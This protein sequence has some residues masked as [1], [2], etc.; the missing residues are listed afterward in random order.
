[1]LRRGGKP[2]LYPTRSPQASYMPGRQWAPPKHGSQF[3]SRGS[4]ASKGTAGRHHL[5][6]RQE[7]CS[8]HHCTQTWMPHSLATCT[9]GR[10]LQTGA[11]ACIQ[12][13]FSPIN[14][15][16]KPWL[17]LQIIQCIFASFTTSCQ[18]Q[19]PCYWCEVLL[20]VFLHEHQCW[21]P[22]VLVLLMTWWW[23]SFHLQ[24]FNYTSLPSA[25]HHHI[26]CVLQWNFHISFSVV[27][28]W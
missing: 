22:D 19:G 14:G 27:N 12:K 23:C 5:R 11:P 9:T 24:S 6:S 25:Q 10:V 13:R 1:M 16:W 3:D 26:T 17:R 21:C 8:A 15:H 28:L 4:I 18:N 20:F 7:Q 2:Q